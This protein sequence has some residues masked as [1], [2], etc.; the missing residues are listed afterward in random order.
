MPMYVVHLVT[1]VDASK[2]HGG[3]ASAARSTR[4]EDFL[5]S[6]S[7]GEDC[8]IAVAMGL[9]GNGLAGQ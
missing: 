6:L 3:A 1:F 2:L 9:S 5:L 4:L 8:V 7:H